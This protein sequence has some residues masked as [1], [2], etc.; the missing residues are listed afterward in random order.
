MHK[1]LGVCPFDFTNDKTGERICGYSV[2]AVTDEPENEKFIGSESIKFSTNDA[3]LSKLPIANVHE[4]VGKNVE[5]IYNRYGKVA[6]L[7]IIGNGK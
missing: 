4:L 2:H 6:D 5:L 3:K 7:R 1:I